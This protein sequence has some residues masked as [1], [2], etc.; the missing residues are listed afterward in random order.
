M[1]VT[2]EI[3]ECFKSSV[4]QTSK[5]IFNTQAV[6]LKSMHTEF[7]LL[8]SVHTVLQTVHFHSLVHTEFVSV[9]FACV[10]L[11]KVCSFDAH[12]AYFSHMVHTIL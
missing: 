8:T 7:V 10:D 9:C 2:D 5:T 1:T 12:D 4:H 3:A 11:H 6:S